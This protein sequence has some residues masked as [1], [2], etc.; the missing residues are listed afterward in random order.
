MFFPL[1]IKATYLEVPQFSFNSNLLLITNSQ[2][3]ITAVHELGLGYLYISDSKGKHHEE[4][5]DKSG[6]LLIQFPKVSK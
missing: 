5:R 3:S 4:R 1:I 6:S 2:R